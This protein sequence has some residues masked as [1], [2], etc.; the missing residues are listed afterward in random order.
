MYILVILYLFNSCLQVVLS[1]CSPYFRRLL[2]ANPCQ[3]PI[4]ILRDVHDK[5]M[6]SLLRY[7]SEDQAVSSTF[8]RI[9]FIMVLL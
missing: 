2:K 9:Y 8:R 6:E 7:V 5:D 3:H 1:A 4:V